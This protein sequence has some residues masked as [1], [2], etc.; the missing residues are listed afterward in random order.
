MA[1]PFQAELCCWRRTDIRSLIA[2][3]QK[4]FHFAAKFFRSKTR[5]VIG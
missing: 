5:M 3:P 1:Q 4:Y 2:P